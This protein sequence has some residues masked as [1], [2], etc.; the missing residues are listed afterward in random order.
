MLKKTILTAA[1]FGFFAAGI[2]AETRSLAVHYAVKTDEEIKIDGNL[3]EAAWQ[4]VPEFTEY[5]FVRGPMRKK[6]SVRILWGRHGIY[7]GV[8]NYEREGYH[9]KTTVRARDGG[10]IWADDSNEFYIDPKANGYGM[11]KFDVNSAGAIGDFWQIDPGNTDLQYTASSAAAASRLMP[12]HWTLE[13]Y[14]SYSDLHTDVPKE[15]DVW[16]IMHRRLA[17]TEGPLIDMSSSG[18]HYWNKHF[19]Y[20]FMT[21][22]GNLPRETVLEQLRKYANPPWLTKVGGICF[23]T[24]GKQEMSGNEEEILAYF[25]DR[26]K[27][28]TGKLPERQQADFRKKL[29]AVSGTPFEAIIAMAKILDEAK[30]A[31]MKNRLDDLFE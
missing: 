16:A 2:A 26:L 14:V 10:Q 31:Q 23:W 17:Y 29:D 5:R 15:G 28:E 11:F 18:G 22:D 30:A 27:E 8:V 19:G 6:T 24:D 20:L 21:G 25:K 7:F 1:A 12:D 4:T 13:F 3:D 9:L